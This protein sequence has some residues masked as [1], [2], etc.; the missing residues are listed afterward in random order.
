MAASGFTAD[1][2][3]AHAKG[4]RILALAYALLFALLAAF[5]AGVAVLGNPDAAQPVARVS[6]PAL[7]QTQSQIPATPAG[8]G[9]SITAETELPPAIKPGP[10]TTAIFAGHALIADP[11]LIENTDDG[12]LP[13]IADDG[14]KPMQVYAAPNTAAGRPRITI[15]LSGLGISAKTTAAAL[16]GLPPSVTLGFAPYASDAQRWVAEARMLGHEVLLELPMEPFDYPDSDPG[17]H[18]LRA[19]LGETANTKLL[20]WALTRFT[21]YTGVTNLGSGGRFLSDSDALSPIMTYVTRRG[22]LFFDNGAASQSAAPSVAAQVGASFAQANTTID[23]IQ[24]AMEIDRRL[25]DL[26][27]TAREKGSAVGAG[28]IYPVTIDRV[29]QWAQGLSGRGFV[30]VPASAIVSTPK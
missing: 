13:R 1:G 3:D 17:P 28:Y 15:V 19:G 27:A 4:P 18:T 24:A 29:S 26:E 9:P 25:S 16:A 2:N 11:T 30:L 20:A 12:P 23:S 8:P 7:P 10:I 5:A 21:G 22:L 6:L 14:R